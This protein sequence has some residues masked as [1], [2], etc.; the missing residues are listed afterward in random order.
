MAVA[1]AP[2]VYKPCL[3]DFRGKPPNNGHGYFRGKISVMRWDDLNGKPPNS[4]H[5]YFLGKIS[6][7]RWGLYTDDFSG[8]PP[9][10]GH[11]CFRGKISIMR[12]DLYKAKIPPSGRFGG[13]PLFR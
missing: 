9:N 8:K 12:W 2:A 13:W 10:S 7:M 6:V 11:E 1:Q 5:G 4:G 3:H